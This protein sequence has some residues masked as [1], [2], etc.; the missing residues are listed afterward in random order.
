MNKP[1]NNNNIQLLIYY[2]YCV[3][4]RY[5]RCMISKAFDY[6]LTLYISILYIYITTYIS[7][8]DIAYKE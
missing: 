6:S 2:S 1:L 3:I 5:M 7:Y 4:Y 8:I